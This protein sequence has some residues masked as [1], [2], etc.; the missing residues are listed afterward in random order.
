M[1]IVFFIIMAGLGARLCEEIREEFPAGHVLS[2]SVAPYQSGESP[3]QHYN[4]LL[5]LTSLQRFS[6]PIASIFR[7]N[8]LFA[9]P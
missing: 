4:T 7:H 2:V 1:L 3:L 5:S 9:V 8:S 6:L